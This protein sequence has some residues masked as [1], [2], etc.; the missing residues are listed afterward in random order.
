MADLL[1][2]EMTGQKELIRAFDK[3][4]DVVATKVMNS[5][6]RQGAN[7]F[8]KQAI[9]NA[10]VR[11]GDAG[12]KRLFPKRSGRSEK[13][14]PGFLKKNIVVRRFKTA[15]KKTL[16]FR[17]GPTNEAWYGMFLEFGTSVISAT[18]WLRPAFEGKK[19]QVM[20][21]IRKALWTGIKRETKKLAQGLK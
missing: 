12:L 20:A 5:A 13:R 21:K 4:P 9:S 10:P 15:D 3:L 8:K 18:P 6:M 2:M 16:L 17:A 14:G 11:E 7:I 1:S 19:G